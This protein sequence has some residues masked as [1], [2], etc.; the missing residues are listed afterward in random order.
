[1]SSAKK[2]REARKEI[3]VDIKEIVL[4]DLKKYYFSLLKY[5]KKLFGVNI[6]S[7]ISPS[8]IL[9]YLFLLPFRIIQGVSKP[10]MKNNNKHNSKK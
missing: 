1:M 9:L 8:T 7:S 4:F 5:H 2:R 3:C 6:Y 10:Q